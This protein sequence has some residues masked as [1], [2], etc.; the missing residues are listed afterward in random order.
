MHN[1][2]ASRVERLSYLLRT[3]LARPLKTTQTLQHSKVVYSGVS[4][5][6][7]SVVR[8]LLLLANSPTATGESPIF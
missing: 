5:P 6:H 2:E 3:F 4:D 7:H 1:H 8:L